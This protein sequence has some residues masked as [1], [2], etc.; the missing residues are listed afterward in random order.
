M[1]YQSTRGQAADLG[2][3]EVLLAGLASDGGLYVPGHWPVMNAADIDRLRGADYPSVVT[4]TMHR[5]IGDEIS[6]PEFTRLVADS[7]AGF[8]HKAVAPLKQLD[9]DL[10]L[11]EL[12]HGPT[13]AFKD[14]ALQLVGR[15]FD[16]ALTRR[17]EHL[18]IVGATSGDTGSAAIE[19]CRTSARID[20][21][22]L[23]PKG[24]V[25]EVQRRQ[26][27]TAPG[28]NV[29]AIA[30]D[31]TF[32]D[33]QDM[34]KAL[35]ADAALKRELS[36]SAVNSINWARIAAQIAFYAFAISALG[37]PVSFAVP[38]GNF[39]NSYAAAAA[40]W[41]G[42]P[43]AQVTIGANSNDAL[44]RLIATGTLERRAV[45]PTLSPSM[46]IQAP[47][48]LERLLF[49]L[50]GRSG[51]E[52]RS[53][54]DEFRKTGKLALGKEAHAELK[55]LFAAHA[56]DDAATLQ[57]M[58]SV[59]A[60]SGELIDPH[61]AVAV[62][63]ARATARDQHSPTVVLATAHPAKF[64]DAVTRATK[65]H[66]DLPGRL[67]DLLQRKERLTEMGKDLSALRSFLR[68][69]ARRAAA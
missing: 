21:F 27:T 28:D 68:S 45:T 17:G 39:G 59:L 43:V 11:M 34:V 9:H 3:E 53:Q 13:L 65:R 5:F 10:W 35:F 33:C 55:R 36:L 57:T 63:A 25:S 26:M 18:T 23:F 52:V 20:T 61:T 62:A 42:L 30:V 48:N 4:A 24:R 2:F 8:D 41:L 32:D 60:E 29:H 54:M 40:R 64:P 58:Q 51:E 22:I 50:F 44:A 6:V 7:Y 46:D 19:A 38:T 14:Y 49:E 12:F 15:L 66:P 31:G 56:V 1:R 69:H 37:G 16:R 47:S 67:A